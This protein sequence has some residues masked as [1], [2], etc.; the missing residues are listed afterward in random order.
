MRGGAQPVFV[1]QASYIHPRIDGTKI[2]Y[3]EWMGAAHYTADR[4]AGAMH[5]KVFLLDSIYAGID[6]KHVYGRVDFAELSPQGELEIVVN[7]E[8]WAGNGVR[9]RRAL[10][11]DVAVKGL[12]IAA[13]KISDDGEGLRAEDA[14][15]AF[16]QTFEFKMPLSLLYAAPLKSSSPESPAAN[17]IRLRFSVWQNRLP[18]DALPVEG[19]MELQLLPEQELAAM[20][21]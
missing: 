10:R 6:E 16:G 7:L 19:W 18:I 20:A 1:P 8:S 13:W 9:A 2:R 4:R 5:G 15:V 14:T 3:F 17:K 21:K 12:R 11:L